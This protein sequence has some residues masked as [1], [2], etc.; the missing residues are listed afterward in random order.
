MQAILVRFETNFEH[1]D[2]ER[3]TL[4]FHT[5]LSGMPGFVMAVY[6]HESAEQYSAII[7][8]TD[9][10]A[11]DEAMRTIEETVGAQPHFRNI[12]VSRCASFL[13]VQCD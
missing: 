5:G 9:A 3:G 6:T 13:R 12:H 10:K 7:G 2:M 11:A 4:R 8:W 1:D